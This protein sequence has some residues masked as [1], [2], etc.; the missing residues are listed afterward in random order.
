MKEIIIFSALLMILVSGCDTSYYYP[1]ENPNTDKKN[2]GFNEE[3][4]LFFDVKNGA[5]TTL[6]AE[7]EVK[8]NDTCF[9]ESR[10]KEL[11]EISPGK[12]IRSYVVIMSRA[13]YDNRL[14]SCN[15]QVFDVAIII[16]DISGKVLNSKVVEVGIVN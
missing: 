14:D 3:T 11:G 15:G 2:I 6:T 9:F 7:V 13:N 16:K 8:I 10:D 4:R 1:I 5:Q 12:T